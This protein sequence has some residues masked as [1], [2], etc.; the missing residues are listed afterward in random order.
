MTKDE[1]LQAIHDL[2]TARLFNLIS[3]GDQEL[4]RP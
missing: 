4:R 1:R 3:A 2:A